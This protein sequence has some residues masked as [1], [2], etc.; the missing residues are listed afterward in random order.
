MKFIRYAPIDRSIIDTIRHY[1][2]TARPSLSLLI[3]YIK[4]RPAKK[5]YMKFHCLNKVRYDSIRIY[6]VNNRASFSKTKNI[7][8]SI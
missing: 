4:M 8:S 7:R 3:I 5:S 2:P 1:S 6:S